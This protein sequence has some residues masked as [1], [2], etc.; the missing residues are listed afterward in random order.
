MAMGYYGLS[1]NSG[2]LK[3][4]IY[5]NFMLSGLVEFVSYTACFSIQKLGRNGPHVFG[6]VTAGLA[7][8]ATIYLLSYFWHWCKSTL[9]IIMT[10]EFQP[11][12]INRNFLICDLPQPS[13]TFCII[14]TNFINNNNFLALPMRFFIFLHNLKRNLQIFN[15][16]F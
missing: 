5:L 3:G 9:Y 13:I 10:T 4:S 16:Q 8:L 11:V 15:V 2:S 6:M 14:P 7:C 12:A 1:L